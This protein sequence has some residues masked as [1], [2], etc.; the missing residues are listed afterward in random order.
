MTGFQKK[1]F[2]R[3]R[4]SCWPKEVFRDK[5][6]CLQRVILF[7]QFDILI[8]FIACSIE[9]KFLFHCFSSCICPFFSA[10]N[11]INFILT[12]LQPFLPLFIFAV[13][14]LLRSNKFSPK[15]PIHN[16]RA[17]KIKCYWH[18]KFTIGD[19]IDHRV[20]H[21]A[22]L[23]SWFAS[24]RCKKGFVDAKYHLQAETKD[25]KRLGKGSEI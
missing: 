13:M 14:Q 8:C 20:H 15:L 10:L 9:C 3:N 19:E 11:Q 4:K 5:S 18:N 6:R 12:A 21:K 25:H 16:T 23:E 2:F 24:E 22:P 7:I 1:A 17:N